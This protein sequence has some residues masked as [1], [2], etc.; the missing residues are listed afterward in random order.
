MASADDELART[1]VVVGEGIASAVPDRCVIAVSLRVMRDTVAEAIAD[2]ASLADAAITAM[3]AAGVDE[4]D[5]AT[6]NLDVQDWIDH[7]QSRVAARVAT[8]TFTVAVR[9][10]RDVSALVNE[11]A[12]TAGDSLQING[13]TFAHSDP[14]PLQAAARRDAVADARA[15]A[16]QL[17]EA[18]GLRLGDVLAIG[19]APVMGGYFGPAISLRAAREAPPPMPMMPGDQRVRVRVEVTYAFAR[20]A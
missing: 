7:T 10:L 14:A 1:I 6:R 20:P 18:S 12:K 16:E 11:L 15:R 8:Y 2:V 13:I 19:E 9:G 4:A 3:R 5:L 17:A